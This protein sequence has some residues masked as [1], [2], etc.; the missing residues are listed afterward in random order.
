[1]ATTLRKQGIDQSVEGTF[2]TLWV[3]VEHLRERFWFF[4]SFVLFV[5]LG[6]FSAPIVLIALFKLGLENNDLSE[7]E[8]MSPE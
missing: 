4:L 2:H 5:V 3:A 6:P 7:P 8:A 1:M